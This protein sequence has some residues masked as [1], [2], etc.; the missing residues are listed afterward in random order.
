MSVDLG[1]LHIYCGNGK[2]KTT[3]CMGLAVRAAGGGFK[4]FVVQFMKGRPTGE[5]EALKKIENITVVREKLTPKFS[6]NMT[7]EEKAETTKIHND[8]LL[9]AV[10]AC[11]SGQCQ[12]LIMDELLDAYNTELIDRATVLEFLKDH[13]GAE[14]A[15]SGRDPAAEICELADYISEVKKIK[16]PFDRGIGARKGVEK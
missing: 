1:L 2:G 12:V 14:V 3:A 5:I 8:M 6:F 9:R 16:H 4:V 15:V 10:S 11:K 7:D 13:G